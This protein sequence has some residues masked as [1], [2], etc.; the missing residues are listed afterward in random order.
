MSSKMVPKAYAGEKVGHFCQQGE[1]LVVV[2]YSDLP[3]AMQEQTD[4][5]G[6]LRFIAG[7]IAIH[8]LDREFIRRMAGSGST[9]ESLSFHRADK[10]VPSLDSAG[11]LV[12][13]SAANGVKFELFVF[14]A[15]P[16]ARNPL[17]I[18]TNRVDDF[19]PVK[20]AE[21]VDSAQTCR[22]DQLRQFARW[23]KSA[24]ETISTDDTGLPAMAIEVAPTFGYDEE[25]FIESWKKLSPTPTLADGLYLST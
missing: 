7:S 5:D 17:V 14:D 4:A 2:E 25:T 8:I 1:S 19:S 16:Y 22:D 23:F 24:G 10:K 9:G 21:G 13:P 3:A 12:K 20:N 11:Q 15:L 18:E 6:G